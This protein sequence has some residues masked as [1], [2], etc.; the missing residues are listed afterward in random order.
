MNLSRFIS[1][2]KCDFSLLWGAIAMSLAYGFINATSMRTD[3]MFFLN[4]QGTEFF[5]LL[6]AFMSINPLFLNGNYGIRGLKGQ[7]V[8]SL[9]FFFS[10]SIKRSSLF[11]VKASLYLFLTLMPLLTVWAYSYTKPIIRI[12]LPYNTSADREATK[13]FYLTHFEGAYVQKDAQDKE[14]NKAFV[15]LPKGQVN[16]AVFTLFWVFLT[17][18]LFQVVLFGFPSAM[19]WVSIPIYF[20]LIFLTSWGNFTS[21]T[22]SHYEMGLAWVTQ[23]TFFAFLVLGISIVLSQLYCCRRFVNTEITS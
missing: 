19:R 6:I 17:T 1:L 22:P 16:R 11:Y 8:N 5:L 12:E 14:G 18:L 3:Q 15:V 4:I 20:A 7:Q 2:I 10:K 21:T 9:E 13:Q 23:H